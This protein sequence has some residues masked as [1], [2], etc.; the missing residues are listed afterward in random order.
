MTLDELLGKYEPALAAAFR[1]AIE[2]IKSGIVLR[3]VVD[4]LE[5]QARCVG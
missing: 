5:C 1:Q 2:D 3:V 4:R